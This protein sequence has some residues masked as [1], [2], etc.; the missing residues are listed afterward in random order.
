MNSFPCPVADLLGDYQTAMAAWIAADEA[1][2][3]GPEEARAAGHLAFNVAWDRLELLKEAALDGNAT[4]HTGRML[5]VT[6]AVDLMDELLHCD[7]SEEER[8]KGLRQVREALLRL[9]MASDLRSIP[10]DLLVHYTGLR[11][12]PSSGSTV[13]HAA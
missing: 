8:A 13:N 9:L 12:P 1:A 5:Q 6:C 3:T 7:V 10:T 11:R 2:V 4:S